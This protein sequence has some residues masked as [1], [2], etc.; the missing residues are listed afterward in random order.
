MYR[1]CI[2]SIGSYYVQKNGCTGWKKVG[3]FFQTRVGARTYARD[4]KRLDNGCCPPISTVLEY[5]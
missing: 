1:V 3:P 2:S 5:C 4:L